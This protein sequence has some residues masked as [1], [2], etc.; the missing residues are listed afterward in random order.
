LFSWFIPGF[1]LVIVLNPNEAIVS[2]KTVI[3]SILTSFVLDILV[4]TLL[5][6]LDLGL[7][8]SGLIIGLWLFTV[9]SVVAGNARRAIRT[10]ASNSEVPKR[11]RRPLFRSNTTVDANLVGANPV[12]IFLLV[13]SLILTASWAL[14]VNLRAVNGLKPKPF[15]VL[16]IDPTDTETN[17]HYFK[18]LIDN[19]EAKPMVYRLEMR[20]DS[21]LVMEWEHISLDHDEQ[22]TVEIPSSRIVGQTELWLFREGQDRLYRQVHFFV[23]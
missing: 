10:I 7:T 14:Q 6:V 8:K 20:R 9:L 1:A 18:I 13:C 12:V 16:T 11:I 3:F 21:V 4:G 5:D 2:I 22:W 15:T 17:H 19:Q 23:H